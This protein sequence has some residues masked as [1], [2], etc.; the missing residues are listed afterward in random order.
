MVDGL[1]WED[2]QLT[3]EDEE[4]VIRKTA[5]IIHRFGLDAAAILMIESI[6]PLAYIGG[7]MGRFLI[8]P[9]LPAISEDLGRKGDI[10]LRVFEKRENV[11]KLLSLLEEMAK[12]EERRPQETFENDEKEHKKRGWRRLIPF[13]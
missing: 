11:E 13:L 7:Q 5:E 2:L 9:F 4:K 8:S 10:F 1:F 6:K 12:E 3:E